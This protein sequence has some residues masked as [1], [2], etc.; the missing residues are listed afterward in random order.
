[1]LFWLPLLYIHRP[2]RMLWHGCPAATLLLTAF[3]RSWL[4]ATQGSNPRPFWTSGLGLGRPPGLLKRYDWWSS[5]ASHPCDLDQRE[6]QGF[7]KH[8]FVKCSTCCPDSI[9]VAVSLLWSH[10]ILEPTSELPEILDALIETPSV[11]VQQPM[12][13]ACPAAAPPTGVAGQ[14]AVCDG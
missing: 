7:S 14:T 6:Y 5:L 3:S 12:T 1:V 2:W 13:Y 10:H 9:E 4:C 8:N 11:Q